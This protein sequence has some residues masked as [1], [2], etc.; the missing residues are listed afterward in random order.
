M[1]DLMRAAWYERQ[2][3]AAD[4]RVSGVRWQ[5]VARGHGLGWIGVELH[6]PRLVEAADGSEILGATCH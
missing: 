5:D 3:A 2:R 6:M 1:S 4:V